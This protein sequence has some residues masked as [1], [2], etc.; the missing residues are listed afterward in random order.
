VEGRRLPWLATFPHL[1]AA[2][3]VAF[4]VRWVMT[5]F[6]LASIGFAGLGAGGRMQ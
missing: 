6:A 2:T 4:Q 1:P 3:E 5:V